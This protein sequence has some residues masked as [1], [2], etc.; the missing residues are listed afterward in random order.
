M[1]G[2]HEQRVKPF[3]RAGYIDATWGTVVV[4]GYDVRRSTKDARESIGYC[5]Q[6]NIVF[7][8]LTVE[9]HLLFFAVVRN[10]SLD[11]FFVFRSL[12]APFV[13]HR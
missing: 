1:R 7:D 13:G 3:Q 5:S 2:W 12:K 8:D 10:A 4:G 11:A 6:R 9:E